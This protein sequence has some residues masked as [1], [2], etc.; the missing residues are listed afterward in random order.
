MHAW[1]DGH[2]LRDISILDSPY[3]VAL[4]QNDPAVFLAYQE[5]M[6]GLPSAPFE[7]SWEQFLDLRDDIARNGLRDLGDPIRFRNNGQVDGHHRL[8][9]LCHLYG[10]QSEVL[11]ANGVVTFPVRDVSIGTTPS[12]RDRS[13]ADEPAIAG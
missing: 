12:T 3:Y 9:I 8:A 10:P 7:I 2:T 11:V 4:E 6:R 5:V 13:A 1:S